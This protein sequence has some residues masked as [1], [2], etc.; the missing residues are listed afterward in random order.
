MNLRDNILT[1]ADLMDAFLSNLIHI[2]ILVNC[3]LSHLRI[4]SPCLRKHSSLVEEGSSGEKT[5]AVRPKR[6][7]TGS[8]GLSLNGQPDPVV[9]HAGAVL[10]IFHLLP[11]IDHENRKVNFTFRYFFLL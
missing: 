1:R 9:V 10:S 8:M 7:S 3:R 5:V 4:D 6:S 11:K 2:C